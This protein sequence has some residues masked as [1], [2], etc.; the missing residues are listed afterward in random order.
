MAMNVWTHLWF[1]V[2]IITDR[3]LGTHLVDRELD[4]L[5]R[6]VEAHQAQASAMLRQMEPLSR[7]M[8]IAQVEL[9]VLYLHQRYLVRPESW[10][11]FAP[12]ESA[13]EERNLDLLIGRL[14]KQGLATVRTEEVGEQ[15]YVYHLR[16]DWAA[17]AALLDTWKEHLDSVT[18]SWLDD[19]RSRQWT[20]S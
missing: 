18:A 14:A 9:C 11:R 2:L 19:M 6:H 10:L 16:P 20:N 1:A 4:R 3:L 15:T 12:D 8:H 13:D 7:L 17:I 5:Q